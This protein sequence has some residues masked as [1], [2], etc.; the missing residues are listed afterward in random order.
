MLTAHSAGYYLRFCVQFFITGYSCSN[1]P[2]PELISWLLFDSTKKK[3]DDF[4]PHI[5]PVMKVCTCLC[6]FHQIGEVVGVIGANFDEWHINLIQE[7]YWFLKR[8]Y[9]EVKF[10]PIL[11]SQKT[12]LKSF[13]TSSIA[14]AVNKIFSAFACFCSSLYCSWLNS[15]WRLCSP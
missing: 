15:R 9:I 10:K 11:N 7:V 14:D 13:L 5:V 4:I 1:N 6:S 2:K 8:Q 12:D 3:L